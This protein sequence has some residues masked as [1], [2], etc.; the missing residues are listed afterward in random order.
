MF[1]KPLLDAA[2]LRTMKE[3]LLE[4]LRC[5]LD[6]SELE[7]EDAEYADDGE[8]VVSG[9]SSAPSAARSTRSRTESR[10]CCR[11]TCARRHRPDRPDRPCATPRSPSTSTAGARTRSR[12][13]SSH[14]RR[15][16]GSRSSCVVT[17]DLPTSTVDSVAISIEPHRSTRRTTTSNRRTLLSSGRRR[18]GSSRR[19]DQRRTRDSDRLRVRIARD[20]SDDRS[21]SSRRGDR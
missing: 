8:E 18:L 3:S 12:R 14:S 20:R 15:I 7:L 9:R 6:K 21:Q 4:I 2:S 19:P 1:P 16:G 11:R 5:P 10:T 13:I 17:N